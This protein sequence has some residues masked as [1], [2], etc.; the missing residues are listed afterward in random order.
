M[1]AIAQGTK[2]VPWRLI[3][4]GG[5]AAL[6]AA[7][8]VAMRFTNE[9]NWDETDFIFAG[10]L[11]GLVGLG[12]E[13]VAR[14]SASWAFRGGAALAILSC[15]ALVWVNLA[16][17]MIG[18]EDNGYN[19]GFIALIPAALLG[20]ALVRLRA[21]GMALVTLACGL[22]Q[23]GIALGGLAADQRGAVF[24]AVMAGSWLVSALLFRIAAGRAEDGRR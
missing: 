20:A 7:P 24:S 5:A 21:G 2:R 18:N 3:G 1:N 10:V 9:V 15:F 12:F 11:F 8:L 19:L 4:W 14:A 13:L 22:A 23:I 17:G 16:V 6:L